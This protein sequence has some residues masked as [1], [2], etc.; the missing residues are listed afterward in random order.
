MFLV[1]T[2]AAQLSLSVGGFGPA[3]DDAPRPESDR[4]PDLADHFQWLA[5]DVCPDGE[6]VLDRLRQLVDAAMSVPP[7]QIRAEV[8]T[9]ADKNL[10]LRIDVSGGSQESHRTLVSP[11]CNE[12]A[13]AAALVGA[14]AIDPFGLAAR[15]VSPGASTEASEPEQPEPAREHA[16]SKPGP[17]DP[18]GPTAM[19]AGLISV[20]TPST[21]LVLCSTR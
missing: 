18:G 9:G 8:R 21:K 1:S 19:S 10:N 2:L 17:A 11:D 7:I 3:P 20:Q 16:E 12:L 13:A 15:A 6:Q 4:E 5:P 14:I